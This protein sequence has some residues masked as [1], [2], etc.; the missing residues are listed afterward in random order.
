[1]QQ[2]LW[3]PDTFEE[4]SQTFSDFL[5][6][7]FVWL[8][9][10]KISNDLSSLGID[11]GYRYRK[12]L[13]PFD[14][15]QVI[16]HHFFDHFNILDVH[17]NVQFYNECYRKFQSV[18]KDEALGSL[19]RFVSA[20]AG[21]RHDQFQSIP[22]L[23][24]NSISIS[25]LASFIQNH[26]NFNT[27]SKHKTRKHKQ[28][29]ERQRRIRKIDS[30]LDHLNISK[31]ISL[32]KLSQKIGVPYHHVREYMKSHH[33][34]NNEGPQADEICHKWNITQQDIDEFNMFFTANKQ[35]FIHVSELHQHF[36]SHFPKFTDLPQSTFYKHFLKNN[37]IS[38]KVPKVGRLLKEP[39]QTQTERLSFMLVFL[40]VVEKLKN[41]Y[42]FDE[43]S[44]ELQRNKTKMFEK[45]G[46]R[47]LISCKSQPISIRLLLITSLT[48]IECY[49][50]KNESTSGQSICD[51]IQEFFVRKLVESG[52]PSQPIY[53]VLD[54]AKKNRVDD[55]KRLTQ[56]MNVR[57]FYIIPNSPFLNMIENVFMVLKQKVYKNNF[58]QRY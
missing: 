15:P 6:N 42:F 41:I 24:L 28:I 53:L 48:K 19:Q 7:K 2:T 18:T 57:L 30:K 11:C 22:E 8:A 13:P 43:C 25:T 12:V 10:C 32:L 54:N 50:M 46:S 40:Q 23:I 36:C 38:A 55:I 31:P 29:N 5:L 20:F 1:M 26:N 34:E 51:F 56:L 37:N 45:R 44:F 35:I 27:I 47:P 16:K 21:M 4:F 14:K 9:N 3:N 17:H 39:N 33:D 49:S 52:F 58:S